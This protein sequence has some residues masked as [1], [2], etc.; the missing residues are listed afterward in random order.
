MTIMDGPFAS[1]PNKWEKFE[2]IV[3]VIDQNDAFLVINY[4]N[5]YFDRLDHPSFEDDY[6]HMIDLLNE[7][8]ASFMTMA[9]AYK[10]VVNLIKE[11]L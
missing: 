11:N 5:N 9:D 1:M 8:G 7:K 3:N 4:H 6:I 10:L 2:K